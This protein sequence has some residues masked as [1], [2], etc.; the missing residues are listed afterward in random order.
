MCFLLPALLVVRC[1]QLPVPL[2]LVPW[3]RPFLRSC[4]L[5]WGGGSADGHWPCQ[6]TKLEGTPQSMQL[7]KQ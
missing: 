4:S 1:W 6:S 3:G 5:C 2:K 7:S